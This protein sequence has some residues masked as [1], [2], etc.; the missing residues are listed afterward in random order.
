MSV[1]RM[2]SGWRLG[3]PTN[4]EGIC[5]VWFARTGGVCSFGGAPELMGSVVFLFF[6]LPTSANGICSH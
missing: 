4:A 5:S 3:V 2:G 6:F 1:S